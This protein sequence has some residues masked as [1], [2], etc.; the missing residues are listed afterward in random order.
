M[1]ILHVVFSCNRIKYL[2][3]T[4]ESWKHLDYG[5]H[6]VD[7]LL[8]DDYPRNRNE[9]IFEL[10]YDFFFRRMNI[11]R[12]ELLAK[13]WHPSRCDKWCLS[14]DIDQLTS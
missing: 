1:K 8:I 11:I 6:Q 9:A 4:L 7:R 10:D 13:T 3:K 14:I 5:D 2:T 12:D